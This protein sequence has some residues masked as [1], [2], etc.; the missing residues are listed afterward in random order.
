MKT[1]STKQKLRITADTTL[2]L[3]YGEITLSVLYPNAAG[4]VLERGTKVAIQW[5]AVN[6]PKGNKVKVELVKG[7]TQVWTLHKGRSKSPYKWTVGKGKEA[8]P[9]GD[10]YTIRVS[11]LGGLVLAESAN[12]F[13]IATPQSLSVLGPPVVVTGV[14]SPQYTCIV[15]YN[16]GGDKDVT[17]LAKWKNKPTKY[18]KID[19]TGLLITKPAPSHQETTIT[20]TY[21]KPRLTGILIISL[22]PPP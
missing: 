3:T 17:A 13:T 7:G 15:H 5:D 14:E 18:A 4:I 16:Y 12:Q 20:A 6:L 8:Y 1:T 2:T 11:A 10:D 9:D 19:K 22:M 21:G